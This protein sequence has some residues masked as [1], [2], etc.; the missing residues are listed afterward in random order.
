MLHTGFLRRQCIIEQKIFWI[1]KILL[2]ELI[3]IYQ[4]QQIWNAYVLSS[5]AC[6]IQ[7]TYGQTYYIT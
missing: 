1:Q 7:E 5:N 2:E 6:R 4:I 3:C